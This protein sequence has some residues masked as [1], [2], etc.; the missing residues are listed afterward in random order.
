MN[1]VRADTIVPAKQLSVYHTVVHMLVEVKKTV[2]VKWKLFNPFIGRRKKADPA[3]LVHH[4]YATSV[5]QMYRTLRGANISPPRIVGTPSENL[6]RNVTLSYIFQCM[7]RL[8]M[9]SANF[10]L[11]CLHIWQNGNAAPGGV[12]TDCVTSLT[13]W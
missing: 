7:S 5:T 4:R 12:V 2:N 13:K 6:G 8:R 3:H 10:P 1:V 9:K 11:D